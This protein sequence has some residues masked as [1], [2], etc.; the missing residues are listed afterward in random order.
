MMM[1]LRSKEDIRSFFDP[2]NICMNFELAK[3]SIID[4]EK[5]LAEWCWTVEKS[6]TLDRPVIY[7]LDIETSSNK[8][9][10]LELLEIAIL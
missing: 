10:K 8:K 1:K 4:G 3:K 2:F 9:K 7:S 5:M 6:L